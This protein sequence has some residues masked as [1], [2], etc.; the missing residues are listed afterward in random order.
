MPEFQSLGRPGNS[1]R[2]GFVHGL[3]RAGIDI[4]KGAVSGAILAQDKKG[5]YFFGKTFKYIRALGVLAYRV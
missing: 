5:G 2:L 1:L 4:A 3:G